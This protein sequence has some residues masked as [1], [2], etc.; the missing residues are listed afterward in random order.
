MAT[1]QKTLNTKK[2]ESL[3]SKEVADSPVRDGYLVDFISGKPVKDGPEE[4]EAVQ[5]FARML[6]EDYGYPKLHIQ[7]RPQYRLVSDIF[8]VHDSREGSAERHE[9]GVPHRY[10]CFWRWEEE[11]RRCLHRCRVQEKGQEGR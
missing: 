9:E 8:R 4:R 11:R 1:K 7:T 6:V 5:V 2:G 3:P 10:R